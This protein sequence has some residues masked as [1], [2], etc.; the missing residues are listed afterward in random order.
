MLIK[1]SAYLGLS[2]L[3]M[4]KAV[5]YKFWN[6]YV[7]SKYEEKAKLC[8]MDKAALQ[9]TKTQKEFMWILQKM[10]KHD[11]IPQ[12]MDQTEQYLKEKIKQ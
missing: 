6:D 10:Q 7:K 4:G 12:L 11:L 1:R 3:E 9:F 2:I 8:Y 5:I